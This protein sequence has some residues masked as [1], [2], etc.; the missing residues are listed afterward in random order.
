MSL[1]GEVIPSETKV[2]YQ[3]ERDGH[4]TL[5]WSANPQDTKEMQFW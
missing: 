2:A 5:V 4:S 3:G 1:S